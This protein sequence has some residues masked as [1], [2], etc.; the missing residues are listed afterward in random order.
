VFHLNTLIECGDQRIVVSTV[1]QMRTPS[2]SKV[3]TIGLDRYYETMAFHARDCKGYVEAE[4]Q[5]QINFESNWAIDK[6][7][8]STDKSANDMHDA[9][10]TEI[11]SKLEKGY[12][13]PKEVVV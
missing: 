2:E 4:V 6:C 12:K 5:Q 13:Y 8:F 1:G 3:Q 7:D 9:V 10:V 11:V